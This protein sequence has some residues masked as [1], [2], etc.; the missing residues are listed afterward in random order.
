MQL[1]LHATALTHGFI[2]STSQ[3]FVRWPPLRYRFHVEDDLYLE[4]RAY[5]RVVSPSLEAE[6]LEALGMIGTEVDTE[7]DLSQEPSYF[8]YVWAWVQLHTY[9]MV[10]ASVPPIWTRKQLSS[11]IDYISGFI[12]L[13]GPREIVGRVYKGNSEHPINYVE[14]HFDLQ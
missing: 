10:A 9:S 13:Y 11:I 6:V 1:S 14:V 4:F 8:D 7:G 3:S 12:M 2:D 5:H